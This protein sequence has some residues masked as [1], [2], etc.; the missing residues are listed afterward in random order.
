M[1]SVILGRWSP[2]GRLVRARRALNDPIYA[3]I[4][5]R[6]DSLAGEDMLSMMV[7]ARYEDGSAMSDAAVR[8]ELVTMVMA[9]HETTACRFSRAS[10]PRF[11]TS[12]PP[13]VTS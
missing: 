3:E 7:A 12:I 6:R 4:A 10:D 11:L 1:D 5:R 2:G 13:F 8:D 9:G